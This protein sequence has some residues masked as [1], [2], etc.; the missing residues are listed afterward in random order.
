MRLSSLRTNPFTLWSEWELTISSDI[1]G[2]C[3][4]KPKPDWLGQSDHAL[5][6]SPQLRD[7]RNNVAD[8]WPLFW[9]K[10]RWHPPAP[11]KVSGYRFQSWQTCLRCISR[12][13]RACTFNGQFLTARRR[14]SRLEVHRARSSSRW[15]LVFTVKMSY[16]LETCRFNTW[17]FGILMVNYIYQNRALAVTS[18]FHQQ[19]RFFIWFNL[20]ITF[21]TEEYH[22]ILPRC[23]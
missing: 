9:C 13:G 17:R 15:R 19:L 3:A 5:F 4:Q 14:K 22:R 21:K 12:A 8:L 23:H 6:L 20:T 7:L 11:P 16:S 10:G 18:I 1:F 2:K